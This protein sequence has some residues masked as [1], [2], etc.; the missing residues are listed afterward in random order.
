[1]IF[2]AGQ[3]PVYGQQIVYFADGV[4]GARGAIQ[5]PSK[6]DEAPASTLSPEEERMAKEVLR[7]G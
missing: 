6:R 5:A 2:V 3:S 7:S 4:L 1:L